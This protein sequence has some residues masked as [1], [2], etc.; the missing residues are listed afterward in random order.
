MN[1]GRSPYFVTTIRSSY[2]LGTG[3]DLF[4]V[5]G[6]IT[7]I[8]KVADSSLQDARCSLKTVASRPPIWGLYASPDLVFPLSTVSFSFNLIADEEEI[9]K[10]CC[11]RQP[12]DKSD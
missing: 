7:K 9:L 10:I 5:I 6:D 4:R 12:V 1:D 11:L 8:L 3:K 2:Y